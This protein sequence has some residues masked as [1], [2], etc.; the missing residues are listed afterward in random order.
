MKFCKQENIERRK[1]T[2]KTKKAN[3][4]KKNEKKKL[5]RNSKKL[6]MCLLFSL[7]ECM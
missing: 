3:K 2:L 5:L 1:Y 4:S 7:S 6:C